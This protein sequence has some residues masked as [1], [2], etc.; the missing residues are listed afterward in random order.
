MLKHFLR[1][2]FCFLAV[3][4]T[5]GSVHGKE[6]AWKA[7]GAPLTTDEVLAALAGNSLLGETK[8]GTKV[9]F[10][11]GEAM[12]GYRVLK[13]GPVKQEFHL[14]RGGIL[15][16]RLTD[17]QFCYRVYVDGEEYAFAYLN[18]SISH[19]GKILPGDAF[20]VE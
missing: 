16:W 3:Q 12:N 1:I 4:I 15:C 17:R 6:P 9:K 8:R 13:S 5:F 2:A 18:L 19:R 10:F 7:D 11:F 14:L 20:G